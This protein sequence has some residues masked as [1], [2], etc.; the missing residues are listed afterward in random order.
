MLAIS[1][2]YENR[3]RS[4]IPLDE[5]SN[6]EI[7]ALAK[8]YSCKGM[9]VLGVAYKTVCDGKFIS[10]ADEKGL[11]I[12]GFI[13]FYDPIKKGV[14]DAMMRP[15]RTRRERQG[16]DRGQ[17]VRRKIRVREHRPGFEM[18][19][20]GDQVDG[21]NDEEL[22][23]AVECN[24][25]FSR[26]TPDNKSRIVEALRS[27]GHTVGLLGDGINDVVAMRSADVSISVDTS[28]DIAR[29]RRT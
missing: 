24:E 17:R 21:M 15:Q 10:V 8:W 27:N 29:I 12:I 11:T 14:E 23:E 3:E 18:H 2:T 4:I 22:R 19:V 26:L 7:L 28:V 6:C 9:R 13:A 5:K 16:S 20:T 25:V 1:D